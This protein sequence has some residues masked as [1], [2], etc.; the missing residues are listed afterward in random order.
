VVSVAED[1]VQLAL[2]I[3]E[4]AKEVLK[5]QDGYMW[6]SLQKAIYNTYGG[7]NLDSPD[8]VKNEIRQ[9]KK[10]R[11]D[12]VERREEADLEVQRQD[13]R[14]RHLEDRLEELEAETEDKQESLDRLLEFVSGGAH[15]WP[16]HPKVN[17]VA[18]DHYGGNGSEVIEDVK[19]LAEDRD[20][21]IPDERFEPNEGF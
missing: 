11:R 12:A 19:T 14:I 10:E 1:R 21:Q 4:G 7:G 17:D 6:E 9:A 18:L 2:E 13:E 3:D 16:S 8:A 5:E 15:I 20:L